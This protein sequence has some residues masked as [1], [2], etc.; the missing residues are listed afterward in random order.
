MKLLHSVFAFIF[1][2][3]ILAAVNVQSAEHDRQSHNYLLGRGIADVTGPA[4]GVQMLGYSY[5]G[6][7]TEGLHTRLKSRAFVIA[8]PEGGKRVVFVSVDL[9]SVEQDMTLAVIDRL[10]LRFGDLYSQDNVILS[11]THTHS[12]P[13]GYL[14][15]TNELED[16][17]EFSP[18]HFDR[19]VEG[20]VNSIAAAHA[21]LQPGTLRINKGNVEGAGINRSLIAYLENPAEE[22][23]Q[24]SNNIDKEMT[25]LKLSGD[26]GDMG[27]IN[28]HAVHPTSMTYHNRL[29][30]G[31]H[32]GYASLTVERN[33]NF[34]SD[35][36][37]NFVAAFAQ[38][39]PGDVTSNLHLDNTGPGANDFD[40]TKIIG[41]RQL[42]VALDLFESAAEKVE[43]KID[44]RQLYVDFSNYKVLDQFTHSGPQYTCPAAYGY[45]VGAGSTEDGGGHSLFREGMTEQSWWMDLLI[46]TK[47]GNGYTQELSDCQS[48]KPVLWDFGKDKS[49]FYYRIRSVSVVRIGQLVIL[50]VPAEVTTMAGRRLRSTVMAQLGDW[51]QHIVLA[52]YT[53][54]YTSYV[55]TPEEYQIQQYEGGQ[56]LHGPW[57]LPAYQQVS[58]QL[59]KSL[60]NETTVEQSIDFDDLREK[61]ALAPAVI[62]D[63][64]DSFSTDVS[65]GDAVAL[66]R[67][68]YQKDDIVEVTF[69]SAN[70]ARALDFDKPS[71]L[72]EQKINNTWATIYTDHDWS[73]KIRWQ[74]SSGAYTAQ[75]TWHI[76][77][78]TE[79]GEYRIRHFGQYADA[80]GKMKNFVGA[81][82]N[83]MVRK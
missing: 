66:E 37:G 56:T 11:A 22:R 42:A 54:G 12:G 64:L 74:E 59:A 39:N 51:A 76:P 50:A 52:G 75:V 20:M 10:Q 58:A 55:T 43:G 33:K 40:S 47:T 31:D 13:A 44:Y 4:L 61:S 36:D 45:S 30:S 67:T 6:Q 2:V 68:D 7:V 65:F 18:Q 69:R 17:G 1:P 53:N 15:L 19:I 79:P 32:K 24:Y 82:N 73:T 28:W 81:S 63:A 5:E 72:V 34:E 23:A 3:A 70:P 21:D 8:A 14:E 26:T 35:T 60:E 25:L 80:D 78:D 46:R 71:L 57:T 16:L 77:D 48:P 83:L 9:A 62:D 27:M 29:I 41:D 49:S 38:T